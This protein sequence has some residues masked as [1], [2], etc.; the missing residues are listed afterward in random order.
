VGEYVVAFLYEPQPEKVGVLFFIGTTC[1]PNGSVRRLCFANSAEASGLLKN[2]VLT[3]GFFCFKH[4]LKSISQIQFLG[5]IL[6]PV[7]SPF[8][9]VFIEMRTIFKFA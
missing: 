3:N 7:E 5:S 6:K 9:Y 8:Y 2:P 1:S 4:I